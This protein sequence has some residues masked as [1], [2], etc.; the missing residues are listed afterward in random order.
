[1]A[2]LALLQ[3][4]ARG[5]GRRPR[6]EA[7]GGGGGRRAESPRGSASSPSKILTPQGAGN[8]IAFRGASAA[9]D[10]KCESVNSRSPAILGLFLKLE[11]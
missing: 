10:E 11:T 3:H 2:R 9:S 8:F 7:R 6:D 4:A 1:M 5:E